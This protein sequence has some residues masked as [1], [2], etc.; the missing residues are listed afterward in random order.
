MGIQMEVEEEGR[1]NIEVLAASRLNCLNGVDR[2]DG[3]GGG[4]GISESEI[5]WCY[6]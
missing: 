2:A 6:G 5:S 3:A 1:D 4:G